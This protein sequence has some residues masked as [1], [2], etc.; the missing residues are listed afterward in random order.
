MTVLDFF[1]L[2]LMNLVSK[3]RRGQQ[4]CVWSCCRLLHQTDVCVTVHITPVLP[5]DF[6]RIPPLNI[7][8]WKNP[9]KRRHPPPLN[10]LKISCQDHLFTPPPPHVLFCQ[11]WLT[12]FDLFPSRSQHQFIILHYP[13]LFSC[14]VQLPFKLPRILPPPHLTAKPPPNSPNACCFFFFPVDT[15]CSHPTISPGKY[16]QTSEGPPSG[17]R[18]WVALRRLSGSETWRADEF[19]GS[20]EERKQKKKQDFPRVRQKKIKERNIFNGDT[21]L[22]VLFLGE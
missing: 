6:L 15:N 11:S 21:K 13:K 14:H 19:P 18:C 9:L 17:A 4:E 16:E 3:R 2:Y 5:L 10:W 7:L 1:A 22:S 20:V 8:L 12:L